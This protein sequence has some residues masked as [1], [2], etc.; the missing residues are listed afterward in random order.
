[1]SLGQSQASPELI[2][3]DSDITNPF[4]RFCSGSLALA[5]LDR[6]CWNLASVSA[7]FTTIAFGDSSLWWLEIGT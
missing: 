6:A 1:M 4:R 7:M 3:E 2:P 5:S